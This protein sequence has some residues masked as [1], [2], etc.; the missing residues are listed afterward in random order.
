MQIIIVDDKQQVAITAAKWVAKNI[1]K[2]VNPVL[3]LAAGSTP[4]PLYQ[5]LIKMY[6]AGLIS[7]KNITSFNLDEYLGLS[8]KSKQSYRHF[9]NIN[10]F[11]YIDIEKSKTHFPTCDQGQDARSQGLLYEDK[12]QRAGGVGLQVL[13]IGTNG[14][15]GFNEPK[16]SLDSRTRVAALTQQTLADNSR[17]FKQDEF[18]PSFAMTMGIATILDA[19]CILLMATGKNKAQAVNS[20]INGS[21]STQCPASAL[22]QHKNTVIVLDKAAASMLDK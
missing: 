13:G 14:H 18:Q 3:G 2:K 16:S 20:M 11:N 7:F 22:Q 8:T 17:L 21:L 1:H 10:L 6:Q 15:I 9:M 4:I 5:Q 12:I 19:R